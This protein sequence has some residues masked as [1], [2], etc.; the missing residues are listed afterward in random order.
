MYNEKFKVVVDN[1]VLFVSIPFA[2]VADVPKET[3]TQLQ[4]DKTAK[5][6]KPA[7]NWLERN[8]ASWC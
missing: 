5:K 6:D 4:Q 7:F 2:R 8:I 3:E 1:N